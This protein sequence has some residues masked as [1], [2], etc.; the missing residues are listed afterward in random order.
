MANG[1]MLHIVNCMSQRAVGIFV[2]MSFLAV[3]GCSDGKKQVN[4][5][6]TIPPETPADDVIYVKVYGD[7]YEMVRDSMSH[8]SV[9][10]DAKDDTIAYTYMRNN[11]GFECAE[12]FSPDETLDSWIYRPGPR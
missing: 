9:G 6:V 5:G 4:L 10:F 1:F 2:G 8:F 3:L 11:I 7:S 12:E